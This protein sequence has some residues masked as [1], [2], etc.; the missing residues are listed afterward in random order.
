MAAVARH[1]DR[2]LAEI[3]ALGVADCLL[4]AVH[5]DDETVFVNF[6]AEHGDTGLNA[7]EVVYFAADRARARR[8]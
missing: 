6:L 7:E 8:D 2:L 3:A 4:G 1:D 5:L